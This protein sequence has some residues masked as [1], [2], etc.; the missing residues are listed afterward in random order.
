MS[1]TFPSLSSR[2]VVRLLREHGFQ[3]DRQKGSHLVLYHP[4]DGRRAVVP[5]GRKD[6]P[7][8]TLKSILKEAGI[9]LSD[10]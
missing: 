1:P 8:G 5:V 2:E 9:E 4:G 7:I 6:V 3:E 10:P